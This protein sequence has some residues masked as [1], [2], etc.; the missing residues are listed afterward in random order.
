MA[1]RSLY[2]RWFH[3][4]DADGT[5]EEEIRFHLEQRAAELQRTGVP[6][7]EAERRARLEFG[8]VESWKEECRET[9]RFHLLY[10]FWEDL[11]YG[12]RMLRRNPALSALI[13]FCLTIGIGAN[14]A[15]LS[16]IEGILLRPYPLVAHQER[17]MAITGTNRGAAGAAGE[18]IDIS[19][20][21]FQDL[22]RNS[23]LVESFIVSRIM[24]TTLAIGGRAQKATGSIVSANYFDALGVRPILGRGF[25]PDEDVGRNAHPVTVISYQLWQER[26]KGDPAIVGKTQM[27]NGQPHTI[28][29][30]APQGFYGTFVGWAMQFWV[31]VSMQE[32][33]DT[34]GYKLED[35]SA[36]WIEGYVFLKPGV[37]PQQAQSELDSIARRL[38]AE[39]PDADRA[40]GIKLFPLWDTPFNN[41]GTLLPTL[42]IALAVVIFVLLIA[43]ANVSTLLVV[44]GLGRRHEMT[45]RQAVGARR[46]RLMRQLLTEGL[47]LSILAAIGG[48]L[49][50][51]WCRNLLVL[52]LPARG[53]VRM[54]LP[55]QVDWRV[56][57]LST[58]LCLLATLLFALAPALQTSAVDLAASLK[59]ESGGVVSS[60]SSGRVRSGLV[61]LQVALSFVLIVGAGLLLQ[62]MRRMQNTDP[63]FNLDRTVTTLVDFEGAGYD[64]VHTHTLQDQIVDRLQ[65][66]PGIES[67]A[68]A[69]ITPF[70][71]RGYSAA[72][73]ATDSFT[74]TPEE[75]PT[76]SFN[77]VGPGYLATMGIPLAS[78][79]E[80]TRA[81]DE[82][83]PA[84]AV[85]NEVM[86]GQ[87]WR[88]GDAVGRRLQ[89]NG[90]WYLVVGV[91]RM[92]KYR[93]L[94]ENPAPF[95]WV[96]LRQSPL[97]GVILQVRTS[98][99][100]ETVSQTLTREIHGLD[101]NL[102]P[103]PVITM[104]E[105][106]SR[107]MAPQRV[108][109]LMIAIFA[110][111]ALVLAAIGLYGV[112]S[113]TVSQSTRELGLRVALGA[114]R[115][116]LLRLV[117]SR[118]MVLTITGVALGAAVALG[119][120]RLLGFLL[121]RVSPRD[122]VA[123]G[124]ALVVML[125][126]A[127]LACMLPAWRA[128]RT[129][130]LQALRS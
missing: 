44:R 98:Q 122:P 27:M 6:R 64:A 43:C 33:F 100:P 19:W 127:L 35:R 62:S 125:A 20:P 22:A 50:A 80:F 32:R 1:S 104:R 130:P 15:V 71:Y 115:S 75:Q 112:M 102:A 47:L 16:W 36:R 65:G 86:A 111:L 72:T 11:R 53:G 84:V 21:D 2:D 69:R 119:T 74:P 40:K 126:A 129:D 108:A 118:G 77:E 121:Y 124:S 59:A 99:P 103:S 7:P 57:A 85:V 105:Q 58:A 68:F 110:G 94:T 37:S 34:T 29:G 24:G 67:A 66:L 23:T 109:L 18:S 46:A 89:A 78:G 55:G 83:A 26:Y 120:S 60:K 114:G 92:S 61:L 10:G 76:V 87:F 31:P 41:A 97:T 5:M 95:F 39:Y 56:L 96:P 9:R 38:E 116:Q 13:L 113:C 4:R 81:D 48:M 17:M 101:D 106:V 8:A 79:R 63:G 70:E 107:T 90:R 25:H 93:N 14:A 117:L 123:F 51:N 73:I 82:K 12:V 28:I 49:V 30:V 45:V 52:L 128:S 3:R 91:A 88:E 54:N 42:G